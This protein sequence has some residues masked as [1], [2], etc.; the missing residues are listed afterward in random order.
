MSSF[1]SDLKQ[2]LQAWHDQSLQRELRRVDS[3]NGPRIRIGGRK[4]LNFSSNDYL[5]LATH[6]LLKEAARQAIEKFGAGAG[7]SRLISGSLAPFHELEE[8]LADYK[9]A[10]AALT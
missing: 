7:A 3:A 9:G 10:A 6:P 1:D 4:F 5:D 8:A 2:R